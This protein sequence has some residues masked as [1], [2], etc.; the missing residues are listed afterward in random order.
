M[1]QILSLIRT[2]F[3]WL[4]FGRLSSRHGAR[5]TG[6]VLASLPRRFHRMSATALN[7]RRGSGMRCR[8]FLGQPTVVMLG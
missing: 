8:G 6:Q 7:D 5:T 3:G 1:K 2:V 4:F